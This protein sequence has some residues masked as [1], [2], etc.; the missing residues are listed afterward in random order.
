[1]IVM[2]FMETLIPITFI[3]LIERIRKPIIKRSD[4]VKNLCYGKLLE[5]SL[6]Q[7]ESCWRRS[8]HVISLM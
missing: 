1:M 3:H 5:S 6:D 7:M 8:F 4:F 2:Y